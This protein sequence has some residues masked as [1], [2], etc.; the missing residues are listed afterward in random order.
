MKCCP[1]VFETTAHCVS[2]LLSWSNKT[3]SS[4]KPTPLDCGH[5][6]AVGCAVEDCRL[7]RLSCPPCSPNSQ[8]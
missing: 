8:I 7:H 6:R 4:K 1:F 2:Y 3:P 5:Q